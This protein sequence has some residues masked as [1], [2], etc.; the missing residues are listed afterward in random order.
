M[1]KNNEV[2][3]LKSQLNSS[4][5]DMVLID[6]F[7]LLGDKNRY[8]IMKII[9]ENEDRKLCVGDLA[10]ILDTS[11]SAVSQHLRILEMSGLVEGN[12]N[13]QSMCYKPLLTHPKIREVIKLMK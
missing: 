12:R 3:K 6:I 13:G 1:S 11:M 7:K 10:S 5:A 9:S 2:A 4:E 8:R